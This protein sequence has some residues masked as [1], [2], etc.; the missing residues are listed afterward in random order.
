MLRI[1]LYLIGTTA[2][3]VGALVVLVIYGL[4]WVEGLDPSVSG[5]MTRWQAGLGVLFGFLGVILVEILRI[6]DDRR[7]DALALGDR[8]RA[9][10]T[11]LHWEVHYMLSEVQL[12]IRNLDG[13][14]LRAAP[15][16]TRLAYDSAVLPNPIVFPRVAEQ[17]GL[18]DRSVER[19]AA[20]KGRK[21]YGAYV[22]C[23]RMATTRLRSHVEAGDRPDV[24]RGDV[25]AVLRLLRLT[26][27]EGRGALR[28]LGSLSRLG[29]PADNVGRSVRRRGVFDSARW[30]GLHRR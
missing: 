7:R 4:P 3:F 25:T 28:S 19:E 8:K 10:A 18:F 5:T 9:L 26:M 12:A 11:A 14:D 24:L 22:R 6:L 1:V 20:E 30:T 23:Q 27:S 17:L 15:V 21:F 29:D 16:L 2:V 13:L